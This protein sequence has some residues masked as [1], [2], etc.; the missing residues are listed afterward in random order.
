MP[1]FD[2]EQYRPELHEQMRKLSALLFDSPDFTAASFRFQ[3]PIGP[4]ENKELAIRP[5]VIGGDALWQLVR[6]GEA[7]N[8]GHG[9]A[10]KFVWELVNSANILEEAHVEGASE[11]YHLR[12]TK[13]GRVLV[14]HVR[15]KNAKTADASHDHRKDY[16]LD[17]FDSSA[18]LLALGFTTSEGAMKP[19][20]HAKFRQVNEF[21]RILDAALDE[22]PERP[23]KEKDAPLRFVD[24][25]CGKSYLSFSAKAYVEATRGRKVHLTGIDL[26]EEVIAFCRRTAESLGWAESTE[27][28]HKDIAK[29]K[30]SADP[31]VVLSLHACDTATDEAMAFGVDHNARIILSAPCCQHELQKVL[32]PDQRPHQA[33]LRS[34]ILKERLADLLTDAFRAQVLRVCGYRA[35]VVE[36]VEPEATARNIL[37][38]AARVTRAG[39]GTALADYEDLREAWH[40][41]P[42]LATRLAAHCPAL[43]PKAPASRP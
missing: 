7:D 36:F 29:F 41:T 18:L 26:K 5:V 21:L 33:L 42:Y 35:T 1:K 34:G 39:T 3:E 23:N 15:T 10:K 32:R 16:P 19:S 8:R 28:V 6:A 13:K 4:G 11:A 20:M 27:F 37:I 31:D 40:C 17:R 2:Q 30:P 22:L 43:A 9:P 24:C 12:T 14:E 25:G 38:R